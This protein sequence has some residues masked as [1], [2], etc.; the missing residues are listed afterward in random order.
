MRAIILA[1]LTSIAIIVGVELA[2]RATGGAPSIA[3]GKTPVEWQWMLR[4]ADSTNVVYVVGDS[5]VDWAFGHRTCDEHL[6]RLGIQDTTTVNAGFPGGAAAPLTQRIINEQAAPGLLVINYSPCSFYRWAVT[7]GARMA[8]L[9]LQD[10]IDDRLRCRIKDYMY[11]FNRDRYVFKDHLTAI[12]TGVRPRDVV[13]YKRDLYRDGFIQLRGRWN[14]D[15]AF[16]PKKWSVWMYHMQLGYLIKEKEKYRRRRVEMITTVREARQRGWDV[17]LIRLPVGPNQFH[18]ERS[19]PSPLLLDSIAADMD[20]PVIDYQNDP[21]LHPV[22]TYD[23]SHLAVESARRAS[24]VLAEDLAVY[25]SGGTPA[26]LR[27]PAQG[28]DLASLDEPPRHP[29]GDE[30]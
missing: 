8:N 5:R 7:P 11:T 16:D 14:D 6:R 23:E 21:R 20:V 22:E 3:L 18:M 1:F 28:E 4:Q 12:M 10:L 29:Q 17:L 15:A 25:L 2:F 27:R 26:R 19:L 24:K 13:W 30:Q 9:K